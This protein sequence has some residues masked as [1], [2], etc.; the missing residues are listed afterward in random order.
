[1]RTMLVLS[2]MKNGPSEAEVRAAI[3]QDGCAIIYWGVT[4][5]DH[6]QRCEL[7]S[8]I[9]RRT[10]PDDTQ[11]PGFISQFAQNA[12]VEKIQWL[13]KGISM[14]SGSHQPQPMGTPVA[15]SE[16]N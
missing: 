6:G 2:M 7:H 8:E 4:Y 13:P 5:S 15:I 12:A 3:V 14:G 9:E 11:P 1:M 16:P 10:F